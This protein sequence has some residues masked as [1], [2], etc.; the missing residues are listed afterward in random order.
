MLL[1]SMSSVEF[2]VQVHVEVEAIGLKYVDP[3]E[4]LHLPYR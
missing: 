4:T 1:L 3:L 2:E